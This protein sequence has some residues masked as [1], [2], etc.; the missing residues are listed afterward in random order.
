MTAV[1]PLPTP[2]NRTDEP[3]IFNSRAQA[4]IDALVAMVPEINALFGSGGLDQLAVLATTS[5]GRN[6]LTL[7][8]ASALRAAGGLV[9]GTDV[10]AHH[11]KLDSLVSLTAAADQISYW[12]GPNSLGQTGLSPFIRGLF[13]DGDA[14]AARATLGAAKDHFRVLAAGAGASVTGTTAETTLASYTVPGNLMGAHGVLRMIT[15]WSLT[16]NANNKS[17]R[18]KFGGTTFFAPSASSQANIEA[19]RPMTVEVCNLNASSQIAMASSSPNTTSG[20]PP[21]TGTIDT[22]TDQPLLITGQLANAA[23]TMTLAYYRV[24]LILP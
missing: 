6:L 15:V 24:E 4:M 5:W 16:E 19:F 10:Q 17:P 23:D 21:T 14:A 12:N 2:P 22:T 7:A 20:N 18:I 1:S 13:D 8:D 11:A 9:I 3:A